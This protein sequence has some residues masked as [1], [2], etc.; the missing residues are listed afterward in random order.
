[1]IYGLVKRFEK[2]LKS[3]EMGPETRRLARRLGIAGYVAK[4]VAYG[5]AGLLIIVAAL[6]YDPEKARGLDSALRTLRDQSYGQ[7][8]LTLVALGIGA[9]GLF[10]FFQSRYRKV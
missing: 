10:C 1:V 9:F 5:I 3:G 4:G 6:S 8:L 2:H 7:L